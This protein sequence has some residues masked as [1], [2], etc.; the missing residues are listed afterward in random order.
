MNEELLL[1][2]LESFADDMVKRLE[3]L[4]KELEGL[5]ARERSE[6]LERARRIREEVVWPCTPAEKEL[7]LHPPTGDW[8]L[9][10]SVDLYRKDT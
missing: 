6:G 3:K 4:E 5:R 10:S 9:T 8:R 1:K 7:T 2:R